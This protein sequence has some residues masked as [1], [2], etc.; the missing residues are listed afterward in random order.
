MFVTGV[1]CDKDVVKVTLEHVPD[2]PGI[3]ATLFGALAKDK[4]NLDMIIQSGARDG[5][6]DISFS[7]GTEELQ[8]LKDALERAKDLVHAKRYV[9]VDNVAKVS[10]VG[11]GMVNNP[12]VAAKMFEVL[13]AAGI[14]I[15]MI[16]TS[17]IKVSCVIPAD[18]ADDAMVLLHSSFGLDAK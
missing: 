10:I 11:A 9:I 18:R 13:A 7:S 1:A 15:E 12:G 2:V 16:A 3:A 4:I 17:E 5:C 14:N 8:K 6:N